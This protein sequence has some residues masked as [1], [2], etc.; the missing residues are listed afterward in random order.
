MIASLGIHAS[1]VSPLPHRVADN[2]PTILPKSCTPEGKEKPKSRRHA[3][4]RAAGKLMPRERVS[5]KAMDVLRAAHQ[6]CPY[7]WDGI[8]LNI[9]IRVF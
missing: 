1:S 7:S 4:R 9:P 8:I 3:L 5:G 2:P 6:P